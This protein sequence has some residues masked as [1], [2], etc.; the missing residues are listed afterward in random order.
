MLRLLLFYIFISFHLM[1]CTEIKN[2]SAAGPKE[3]G[4]PQPPSAR[5]LILL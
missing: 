2:S 3:R 4:G 1:H 5:M